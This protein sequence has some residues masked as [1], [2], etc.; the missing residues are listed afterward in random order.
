MSDFRRLNTESFTKNLEN[1]SRH[2]ILNTENEN[3]DYT[4]KTVFN[5]VNQVIDDDLLFD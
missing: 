2:N 3:A 5:T 4:A 1:V